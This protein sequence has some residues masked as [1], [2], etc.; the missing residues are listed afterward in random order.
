M[1]GGDVPFFL[2]EHLPRSSIASKHPG[3]RSSLL[4]SCFFPLTLM[5]QFIVMI[6]Q[7][8]RTLHKDTPAGVWKGLNPPSRLHYILLSL[9]ERR[10]SSSR[11]RVILM[12]LS[13]GAPACRTRVGE[14]SILLE[15]IPRIQPGNH[16]ANRLGSLSLASSPLLL[17][18]CI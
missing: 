8:I 11:L 12:A 16:P 9:P 3:W 2:S 6:W 5:S 13:P 14:R 1:C 15:N 17:V 18:C 7:R 4:F 10:S